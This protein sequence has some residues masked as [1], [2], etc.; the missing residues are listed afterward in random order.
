MIEHSKAIL[1]RIGFQKDFTKEEVYWVP[2]KDAAGGRSQA[3]GR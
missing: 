2:P 1:H 3:A